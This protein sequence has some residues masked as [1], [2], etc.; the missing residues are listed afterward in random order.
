[1]PKL[2]S[3]TLAPQRIFHGQPILYA[4][5][6]GLVAAKITNRLVVSCLVVVVVVV[7]LMVV[8]VIVV[9]VMMEPLYRWRTCARG[10]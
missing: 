3:L 5:L 1:V 10:K 6:F 7:M 9:V 4:L 8:M 2:A